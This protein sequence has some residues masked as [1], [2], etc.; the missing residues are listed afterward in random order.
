MTVIGGKLKTKTKQLC[1]QLGSI[2]MA[3]RR[4]RPPSIARRQLVE[5]EEALKNKAKKLK[6]V[7]DP[8]AQRV[9]SQKPRTKAATRATGIKGSHVKRRMKIV[10]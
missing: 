1:S 5:T 8:P 4:G 2:I 7:V 3:R 6:S 10:S 9:S